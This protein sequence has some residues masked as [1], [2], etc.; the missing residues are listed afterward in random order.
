MNL[1]VGMAQ[2]KT[3][4]TL[5]LVTA[6]LRATCGFHNPPLLSHSILA[7]SFVFL[8]KKK[9]KTEIPW[10]FAPMLSICLG[11]RLKALTC[12]HL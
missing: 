10:L 5:T 7:S 12:A 8:E 1:A 4:L 3:A 9:K 2:R 6:M 11:R